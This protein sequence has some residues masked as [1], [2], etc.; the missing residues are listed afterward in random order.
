MKQIKYYIYKF[1][2]LI[3]VLA[4]GACN[5]WLDISPRTEIKSDDNFSSEQGYKDAL[6]GVYILMTDQAV[7]GKEMTFGMV[8]VLAQYYTGIGQ[9]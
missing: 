4:L 6:T 2:L 3:P 7:Y 8:D 1:A 5:D 9:E